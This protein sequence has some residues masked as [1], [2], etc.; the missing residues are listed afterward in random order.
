M[1]WYED[2]RCFMVITILFGISAEFSLHGSCP[3]GRGPISLAICWFIWGE[4]DTW[5]AV[6]NIGDPEHVTPLHISLRC[7]ENKSEA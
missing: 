3:L 1:S 4:H 6:G 5:V 7:R 2:E